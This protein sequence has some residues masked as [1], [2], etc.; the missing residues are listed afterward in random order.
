VTEVPTLAG[1]RCT[2]RALRPDDAPAIARHADDE[3]VWRHLFEGFPRPYTQAHAGAWCGDQHRNTAYGQIWAVAV[4]GEAAGCISVRPDSGWL[5]C[6]AEVGYWIGRAFWRRGI[7]SEAL[8]LV[9]AHAFDTPPEVTRL[10]APIFEHNAVSQ[11]V[12]RRCGFVLEG[13][14]PH[15]AIKGG[16]LIG[17]VVYGRYR[18]GLPTL[19]P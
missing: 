13:R 9:S 7:A 12:A 1:R 8:A 6:N 14:F 3:G 15:S 17:R 11:A 10:Y 5:R 16:Q 4:D 2:L 19:E 18:G